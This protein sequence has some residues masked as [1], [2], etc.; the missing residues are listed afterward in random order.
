MDRDAKNDRGKNKAVIRDRGER[1]YQAKK[2]IKRF[3]SP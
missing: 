2:E 3:F 1:E